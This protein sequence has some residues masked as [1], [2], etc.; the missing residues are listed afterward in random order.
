M[1]RLAS[2]PPTLGRWRSAP[3]IYVTHFATIALVL[4]LYHRLGGDTP[5]IERPWV[6]VVAIPACLGVAYLCFRFVEAP[7]RN[8]L[9]RLR[10]SG[11]TAF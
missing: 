5:P 1:P 8:Y 11:V 6:W 3:R 4:C 10:D 2:P 7:C 9:Q